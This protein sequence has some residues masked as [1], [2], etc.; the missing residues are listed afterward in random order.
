MREERIKDFEK[1]V[2]KLTKKELKEKLLEYM[3]D[4]EF[5]DDDLY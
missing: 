3:T 5:F 2:N 4:S 1:Y